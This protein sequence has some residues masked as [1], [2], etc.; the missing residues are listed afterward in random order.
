MKTSARFNVS[1]RSTQRLI[2]LVM[3]VGLV[4]AVAACAP[5]AAP[6]EVVTEE[7]PA[8]EETTGYMPWSPVWRERPALAASSS[9]AES[10]VLRWGTYY[11]QRYPYPFE[12]S[13]G[14]AV[15]GMLN[16]A[17]ETLFW[18]NPDGT[19]E[20][21]L[22]ESYSTSDDETVW[23][24][25]VKPGIQAVGGEP[26]T[27][28]DVKK[29]IE[30]HASPNTGSRGTTY[31]RFI[32]GYDA[33]RAEENPATELEG[34]T[35]IDDLTVEIELTA[36]FRDFGAILSLPHR[37]LM[38]ETSHYKPPTEGE[39]PWFVG[40]GA[41][42]PFMIA[43]EP[44]WAGPS[45]PDSFEV[46]PNPNWRGDAPE[47]ERVVLKYF[48]DPQTA[49]IAYENDEYDVSEKYGPLEAAE[50][51]E[52]GRVTSNEMFPFQYE[53]SRSFYIARDIPPMDDVNVR[54]ALA[55]AVDFKII[56]D[57]LLRGMWQP[58]C[59]LIPMGW[60]G[61]IDGECHTPKYDPELAR[62]LISESKY[63]SVENMP[64]I[65]LHVGEAGF[66][67]QVGHL[68]RIAQAM[69]QYWKQNL[70]LE[71]VIER[72]RDVFRANPEL[73]QI[74]R[75][76]YAARYPGL[77]AVCENADPNGTYNRSRAESW[78]PPEAE[79]LCFTADTTM[80]LAEAIPMYQEA[81]RQFFADVY[82]IG[83][84]TEPAY[85]LVKPWVSDWDS[86]FGSL[87]HGVRDPESLFIAEH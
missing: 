30:L 37:F 17:F 25:K 35:V 54:Q 72:S 33:M 61:Y 64:Q 6:P 76:S 84:F 29:S 82:S 50:L 86:L 11:A 63:G 13:G 56:A 12:T 23:T 55:H 7:V 66:G 44:K 14:Y 9:K 38:A 85:M 59:Q 15:S 31:A 62:Q 32:K 27:A 39:T 16:M 4:L 43:T 34:I 18:M 60:P 45:E 46:V 10:Q 49:L 67:G 78:G 2:G 81:G 21:R 73:Y 1:V 26:F 68:S 41:T 70:G 24:I 36:P 74:V 77:S 19:L 40:H 80:D 51:L 5:A 87:D 52:P 8:M 48:A 20:G 65:R 69:Q 71:V 22:A 42:G 79:E 47:L 28:E 53:V 75:R 58:A 3:L 83:H 57:T